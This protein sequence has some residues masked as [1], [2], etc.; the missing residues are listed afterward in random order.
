V[1]KNWGPCEYRIGKEAHKDNGVHYHA[2]VK[3]TNMKRGPSNMR[4]WDIQTPEGPKHPNIIFMG[5][6]HRDRSTVYRY[7][8]KGGDLTGDMK[9]PDA[10]PE[11]VKG[12][13]RAR[14]EE[15]E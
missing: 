12:K 1:I 4:A 9:D 15:R 10:P 13:K 5:K 6:T 2:I 14:E 8:T 11:H 7:V 3:Y